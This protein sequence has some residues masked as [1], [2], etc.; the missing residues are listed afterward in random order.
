MRCRVM[1][2]TRRTSPRFPRPASRFRSD[3]STG[4]VLR[5]RQ[6]GTAGASAVICAKC[7]DLENVVAFGDGRVGTVG[8]NTGHNSHHQDQATAPTSA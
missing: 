6:N 3:L 7:H 8:S 2:P 1:L 4:S 5:L